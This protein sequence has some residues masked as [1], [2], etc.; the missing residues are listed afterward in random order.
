M[1][2]KGSGFTMSYVKPS[3]MKAA[4][5]TILPSTAFQIDMERLN[6]TE[7]LSNQYLSKGFD[8]EDLD[9]SQHIKI[10]F[11]AVKLEFT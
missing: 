2:I 9:I 6:Y 5:F 10:R 1:T 11:H 8:F 4:L 7:L 3:G